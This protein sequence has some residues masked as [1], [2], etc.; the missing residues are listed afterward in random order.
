MRK[1]K[2]ISKFRKKHIDSASMM[3]EDNFENFSEYIEQSFELQ[4][5]FFSIVSLLKINF[6]PDSIHKVIDYWKELQEEA[7]P[8]EDTEA[9]K[10]VLEAFVLRLKDL[11]NDEDRPKHRFFN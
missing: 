7:F 3:V 11:F 6:K 2:H 4:F 5:M 10:E 8:L 1:S 9:Y